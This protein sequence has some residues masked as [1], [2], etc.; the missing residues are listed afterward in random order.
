MDEAERCHRVAFLD[1]GRVV[2]EGTVEDLKTERG[3]K[4]FAVRGSGL[5][6]LI[7][8]LRKQPGI[9]SVQLLG[10]NL[11]VQAAENMT[12]EEIRAG[13]PEKGRLYD[14]EE[15]RPTLEDVFAH[16]LGSRS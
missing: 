13:L 8:P 3:W 2:K 15:I 5:R 1:S 7:E 16:I 4:L 12:I 9:L 11:R 6:K 10:P 14:L